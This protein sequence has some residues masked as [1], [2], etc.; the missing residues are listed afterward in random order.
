MNYDSPKIRNT[1]DDCVSMIMMESDEWFLEQDNELWMW[2]RL[3][4]QKFWAIAGGQDRCMLIGSAIELTT[5]LTYHRDYLLEQALHIK[6]EADRRHLI[7][8]IQQIC[9]DKG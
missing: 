7:H 3:L 4:K 1:I 6:M 8:V 5:A 9:D 2:Q